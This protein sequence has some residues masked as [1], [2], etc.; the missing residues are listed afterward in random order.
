MRRFFLISL[1]ISAAALCGGGCSHI[2]FIGKKHP[3]VDNPDKVNSRVASQT[4]QEFLTRW[5]AKRSSELVAQGLSPEAANAQATQEFREKF[6]AT[7]VVSG[8]K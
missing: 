3:K 5:V 6:A 1:A 2:P 4:E 8:V 7:T